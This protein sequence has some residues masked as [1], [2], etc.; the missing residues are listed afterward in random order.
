[1]SGLALDA[2]GVDLGTSTI[3]ISYK[4]KHFRIAS[5]IG[6]PNPGG[7]TS[8][9]HD[10]SW[11]KNLVIIADGEE[12]YVGDLARLQ[13]LLKIPLAREG[14]MKGV[15][16]AKI[17]VLTAIG[18]VYEG[19]KER[20]F[21]VSTGVPVATSNSE[22]ESLSKTIIGKHKF[23]IR[24]DATGETKKISV[25]IVASP[26]LPEP[27]GCY[28]YVLKTNKIGRASCRERV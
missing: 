16:E 19:G 12:W 23:A 11:E 13:S 14:K 28:Y 21:V 17:A 26:V 8:I 15:K 7:F 5:I 18:L 22:M 2:V 20:R 4:D 3:K 9:T 27:Y 6:E 1:M 24:N 10:T 25:H